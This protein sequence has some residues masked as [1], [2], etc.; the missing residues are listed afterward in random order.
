MGTPEIMILVGAGC[1]AAALTMLA[2]IVGSWRAEHRAAR[3]YV[4]ELATLNRERLYLEEQRAALDRQR[5]ALGEQRDHLDERR[6][7]PRAPAP[8]VD[9]DPTVR[10]PRMLELPNRTH[11]RGHRHYDEQ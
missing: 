9:P 2:Y 5:R 4:D 10:L 1:V 11:K 3:Q 6:R 7:T 8:P